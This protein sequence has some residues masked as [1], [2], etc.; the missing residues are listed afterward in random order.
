[1]AFHDANAILLVASVV[2]ATNQSWIKFVRNF[3]SSERDGR[4]L[5]TSLGSWR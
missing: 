3:F 1:M 5:M 4:T 2:F